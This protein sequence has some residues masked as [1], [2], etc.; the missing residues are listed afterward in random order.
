[1][2]LKNRLDSSKIVDIKSKKKNTIYEKHSKFKKIMIS[3]KLLFL[4]PLSSFNINF[5]LHD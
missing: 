3:N 4:N 2:A 5:I 1:M